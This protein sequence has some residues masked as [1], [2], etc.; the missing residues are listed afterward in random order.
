MSSHVYRPSEQPF[1]GRRTLCRADCLHLV[2]RQRNL[3]RL[4]TGGLSVLFRVPQ[5]DLQPWLPPPSERA[6]TILHATFG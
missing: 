4:L 2:N 1:I 6:R 3:P 5:K